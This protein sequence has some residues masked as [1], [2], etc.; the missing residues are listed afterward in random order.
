VTFKTIAE[1]HRIARAHQGRLKELHGARIYLAPMPKDIVWENISREPAEVASRRTFGFV[2]IGA[3]CFFN[4]VPVSLGVV[5][6]L[7]IAPRCISSGES[8]LP[9]C[10]CRFPGQMEGSWAVGQLDCESRSQREAHVA[11]FDRQRCPSRHR[12]VY[13]RLHAASDHQTNQQ[14]SR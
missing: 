9:G 5:A 11:V 14:V 7:T 6:A 8:Q 2:F 4:T 10:L 12:L 1:A 13:F 3:V